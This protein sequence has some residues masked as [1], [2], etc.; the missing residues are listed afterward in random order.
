MASIAPGVRAGIRGLAP[1]V[2]QLGYAWIIGSVTL[3][4]VALVVL[5]VGPGLPATAPG[6]LYVL[7]GRAVP[8]PFLPYILVPGWAQLSI[9]V[10]LA[11]LFGALLMLGWRTIGLSWLPD[12]ARG[13][14]LWT[15]IVA[16]AGAAAWFYA[17]TVTFGAGFSPSAQIVLAYLGGGLP[18]A[19]IAAILLHRP[20]VSLCAVIMSAAL[21]VIG[22]ILVAAH[23]PDQ[24]AFRLYFQYL[25]VVV[26]AS[27]G[28][29]VPF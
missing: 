5:R 22:Y 25:A 1:A 24:S 19:L 15:V 17:G 3:G 2:R 16:G 14:L 27:G 6:G 29:V 11:A 9:L 20:A 18:F 13:R 23:S 26:G 4:T 7:P 12:D 21:V 28:Q 8:A 10:L